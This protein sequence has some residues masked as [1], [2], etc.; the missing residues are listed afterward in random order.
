MG[1][2]QQPRVRKKMF[3]HR[4][5]LMAWKRGSPQLK[6]LVRFAWM[7]PLSYSFAFYDDDE[8]FGCFKC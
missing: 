4:Q 7:Q 3:L 6:L 5:L 1:L 2:A 8:D